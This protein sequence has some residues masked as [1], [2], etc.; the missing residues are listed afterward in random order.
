MMNGGDGGV[1]VMEDEQLNTRAVLCSVASACHVL[2]PTAVTKLDVWRASVYCHHADRFS[3][4][5]I[6]C[7]TEQLRRA[8][9]GTACHCHEPA[10]LR[11]GGTAADG[12]LL[13]AMTVLV[14]TE[15]DQPLTCPSKV[16]FKDETLAKSAQAAKEEQLASAV[17]H[18]NLHGEGKIGAWHLQRV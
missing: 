3:L 14:C 15:V 18:A 10:E 16:V 13:Q 1:G 5:Q 17:A 11:E 8:A 7:T 4:S 12:L 2:S 6:M 9:A